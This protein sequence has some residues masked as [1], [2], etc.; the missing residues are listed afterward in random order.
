MSIMDNQQLS[1]LRYTSFKV[2]DFVKEVWKIILDFPNYS[3][4]NLG[5]VKNHSTGLVLKQTPNTKGYLSVKL[6]M[7]KKGYIKRVHIIV[8]AYFIKNPEN[9]PQLNHKYGKNRNTIMDLEWVTQ[10]ENMLHAY[11]TG[12]NLPARGELSTSS[13]LSEKDVHRICIMIQKGLSNSD[14]CKSFSVVR[15]TISRIRQRKTWCH[16]STNYIW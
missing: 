5:R 12:L 2:G 15:G 9:K 1:N 6:Y 11:A 8:G 10:S 16:I 14:I 7:N 3:I 4:S 13:K